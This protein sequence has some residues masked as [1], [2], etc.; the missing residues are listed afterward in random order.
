MF[1]RGPHSAATRFTASRQPPPTPTQIAEA[2]TSNVLNLADGRGIAFSQA[3]ADEVRGW[4]RAGAVGV[5]IET[6]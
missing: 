2:F 4:L 1:T 6:V 5:A 3:E